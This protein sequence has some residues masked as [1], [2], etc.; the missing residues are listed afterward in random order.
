[1]G[2]LSMWAWVRLTSRTSLA[3]S[4]LP[5]WASVHS[6]HSTRNSLPGRTEAAGGMSGCQRLWPG[7]AWSRMD[8]DWSTL[9]TTSGMSG[10]FLVRDR[11]WRRGRAAW[12]G[13]A[14]ARRRPGRG[15][16][17]LVT[18]GWSALASCRSRAPASA[19]WTRRTGWAENRR[20]PSR[21]QAGQDADRAALPMA[22]RTVKGPQAGQRYSYSV[23]DS[24][25]QKNFL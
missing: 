20:R 2:P 23:T 18:S 11:Y 12:R 10:P 25:L 15:G 4:L 14:G 16:I 24:L 19:P 9:K 13:S 22:R 7:T 1:M 17:V 21:P 6:R 3:E 5:S 8:L